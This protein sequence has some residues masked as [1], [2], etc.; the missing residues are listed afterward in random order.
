[1][2]L[3]GCCNFSEV[4]HKAQPK[5]WFSLGF[6]VICFVMCFLF[7]I[8]LF[9]V[10]FCIL[11]WVLVLVSVFIFLCSVVVWFGLICFMFCFNLLCFSLFHFVN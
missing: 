7:N 10:L 5:F 1:M 2:K 9:R 6:V 3:I 8:L 11:F 4:Q